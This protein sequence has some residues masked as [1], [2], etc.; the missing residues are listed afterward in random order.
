MF[1][2][3]HFVENGR[4]GKPGRKQGGLLG[5]WCSVTQVGGDTGCL[6]WGGGSG[7]G[8]ISTYLLTVWICR[9]RGS[10]GVCGICK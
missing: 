4:R 8:Q 6:D 9:E 7:K 3:E 1:R 5:S 10:K 2:Q